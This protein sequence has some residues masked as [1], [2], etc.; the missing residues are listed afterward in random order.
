[1]RNVA[2]SIMLLF[3]CAVAF[4]RGP[5]EVIATYHPQPGKA[6]DLEK[7]MWQA[8]ETMQRLELTGSPVHH[9]WRGQ[10]ETGEVVLIENFTWKDEEIPD[11]APKEI[12]AI[13]RQMNKVAKKIDVVAVSERVHR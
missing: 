10:S 7:L 5:E 13:W 2:V 8:W 11:H 4:A 9:I 3:A 6:D 1:M 12:L